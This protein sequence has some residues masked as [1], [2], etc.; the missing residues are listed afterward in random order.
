M[1]LTLTES[2]HRGYSIIRG[3]IDDQSGQ[4]VNIGVIAWDEESHWFGIRTLTANERAL[5]V[6]TG[7]KELAEIAVKQLEKWSRKHVVPYLRA[8]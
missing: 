1:S 2:I 7:H 8:R 4:Q 5:G 6:T 3:V